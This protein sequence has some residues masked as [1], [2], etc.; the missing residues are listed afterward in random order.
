MPRMS[1]A[2]GAAPNLSSE[3]RSRREAAAQL[4]QGLIS[5]TFQRGVASTGPADTTSRISGSV[6]GLA[7][8]DTVTGLA[9]ELLSAGSALSLAKLALLDLTGKVLG[10]TADQSTSFNASAGT[11]FFPFTALAQVPEDDGYFACVLQVGTTGAGV[12]RGALH[13]TQ[14]LIGSAR[15]AQG[16]LLTAQADFPAVGASVSSVATLST[17]KVWLGAYV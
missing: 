3:A 17:F 2:D 8:G 6:L 16:F 10:V 5:E 4:A 11:K 9:I 15:A 14:A 1:V 13:G 7:K 12:L